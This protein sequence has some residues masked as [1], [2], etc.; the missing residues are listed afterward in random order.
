M[1]KKLVKEHDPT[2]RY[3]AMALL[4]D[5]YRKKEFVTGLLYVDESRPALAKLM[6]DL[7]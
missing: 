7:A 5:A 3:T 2:N 4:E 6:A 1:L